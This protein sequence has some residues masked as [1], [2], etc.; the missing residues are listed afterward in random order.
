M[1]G[2]ISITLTSEYLV[3]QIYARLAGELKNLGGTVAPVVEGRTI[4]VQ[5]VK[6]VEEAL[7]RVVKS[8]PAAVFASI[9]FKK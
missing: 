2:E 7:W 5:Y 1:A 3:R 8:T 9:D 4:R 6:G